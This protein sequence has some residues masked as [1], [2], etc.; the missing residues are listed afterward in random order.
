MDAIRRT[1]GGDAQKA[2]AANSEPPAK[3]R[4]VIRDE[5]CRAQAVASRVCA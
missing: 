4:P 1:L 5:F 2:I 3:F